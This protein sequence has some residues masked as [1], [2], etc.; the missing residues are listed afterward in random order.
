MMSC[1]LRLELPLF[2]CPLPLQAASFSMKKR[3]HRKVGGTASA[4]VAAVIVVGAYEVGRVT[5]RKRSPSGSRSSK[6]HKSALPSPLQSRVGRGSSKPAKCT[7]LLS[8]SSLYS[9]ASRAATYEY[10]RRRFALMQLVRIPLVPHCFGFL[11][12]SCWCSSSS[13]SHR[14]TSTLSPDSLSRERLTSSRNSA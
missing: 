1:V 6:L 8:R 2:P 7:D 14:W 5:Y 3:G 12:L 11:S 9:R 10:L 4:A 13:I